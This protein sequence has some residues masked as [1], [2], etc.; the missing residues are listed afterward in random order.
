MRSAAP[1]PAPADPV[2][3]IV[4]R[5]NQR[6]GRML[7]VVDLIEAQT[8]SIR[9]AAS[10]VARLSAGSSLLVGARPGGAGKT[11]VMGA[12]LAML[13]PVTNARLAEH[14]TGWERSRPG[15]LV[16]AYE[17]GEG[18]YE[19]YIWGQDLREFAALRLSGVR[20]ATNL[21]AD[22]LEE[23]RAQIVRENGVSEQG[24]SAFG[25]FVPVLVERAR[26]VERRRIIG[27]VMVAAGGAVARPRNGGWASLESLPPLPSEPKIQRFL[28][29]A[30]DR[31][32]RE[33]AQLRQ[34]WL[35]A[36]ITAGA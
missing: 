11:T 24:L 9:L 20:I 16:V 33:I 31:G 15:D 26:G 34:T 1:R 27:Q 10:I 4:E 7:S 30:V 17:I 35:R 6:G 18:G 5:S 25:M 28:E 22:T 21:H 23:A 13:P 29:D 2:I 8:I 14:G 19:A 3:E 32:L 12:F 36:G